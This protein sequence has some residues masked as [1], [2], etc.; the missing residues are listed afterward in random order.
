MIWVSGPELGPDGCVNCGAQLPPGNRFCSECGTPAKA[1]PAVSTPVSTPSVPFTPT[2]I[3]PMDIGQG[4]PFQQQS[5]FVQQRAPVTPVQM[6]TPTSG[7]SVA[8]FSPMPQGPHTPATT[9]AATQDTEDDEFEPVFQSTGIP[10]VDA[11]IRSEIIAQRNADKAAERQRIEAEEQ[12]RQA[13]GLEVRKQELAHMANQL[14]SE[15][16][17]ALQ[18]GGLGSIAR[19]RQLLDTACDFEPLQAGGPADL[20]VEIEEWGLQLK[21]R[22]DLEAAR[23]EAARRQ[24]EAALQIQSAFRGYRG[25][26]YATQLRE[27]RA[28][29]LAAREAQRMIE[30]EMAKKAVEAA[31]GAVGRTVDWAD[32][33][34]MQLA[35]AAARMQPELMALAASWSERLAA[36]LAEEA[37]RI[38]LEKQ[39]LAAAIIIQAGVRGMQGRCLARKRRAVVAAEAARREVERVAKVE[40]V[41]TAIVGALAMPEFESLATLRTALEEA[42]GMHA[43]ELAAD[44]PEWS[45]VLLGRVERNKERI[46]QQQIAGARTEYQAIV[47]AQGPDL[48]AQL[49]LHIS[50]T[51]ALGF[52]DLS[53]DIEEWQDYADEH[54][55]QTIRKQVQAVLGYNQYDEDALEV[56]RSWIEA[57]EQ[58]P[59]NEAFRADI[60]TWQEELMARSDAVDAAREARLVEETVQQ[61][62]RTLEYGGFDVE[63]LIDAIAKAED[64]AAAGLFEDNTD[65]LQAWKNALSMWQQISSCKLIQDQGAR[66]IGNQ[67]ALGPGASLAALKE[68]LTAGQS[69]MKGFQTLIPMVAQW[70]QVLGAMGGYTPQSAALP[71]AGLNEHGHPGGAAA[72]QDE[73][74]TEPPAPSTAAEAEA[75]HQMKALRTSESNDAEN[76]LELP[77][78]EEG[79]F[80]G[81][82][83]KLD[84]WY[85]RLWIEVCTGENFEDFF[86]SSALPDEA[87]D[88]LWVRVDLQEGKDELDKSEFYMYAAFV[89]Q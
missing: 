75:A 60:G 2:P 13:I 63:E 9:T 1:V 10:E 87:L 36:A 52:E 33:I 14:R 71:P 53:A 16:Q 56:F 19:L 43:P 54:G 79:A 35:E 85:D 45:G 73:G 58:L 70:K 83:P 41:R 66:F 32:E 30:V 65:E 26:R 78:S 37:A 21:M 86:Y 12:I 4:T 57:A 67:Q 74:D 55:R 25:R 81:L 72:D 77:V 18:M 31:F 68:T 28:T 3:A 24:E 6:F 11:R 88:A 59:S 5:P 82:S 42:G 62:R 34:Q 51:A 76:I 61:G 8:Q 50:N 44:L 64:F 69:V 40:E 39:Q 84:Q 29:I 17:A 27:E 20:A 80:I 49:Q 38:A 23:I 48:A 15:V 7:S 46:R 89:P 22:E 47:D